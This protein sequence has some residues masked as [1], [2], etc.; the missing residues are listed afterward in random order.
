MITK[1]T[2]ISQDIKRAASVSGKI[3]F[4]L[5]QSIASSSVSCVREFGD[6]GIPVVGVL[7]EKGLEG[8]LGA[9]N[10][11]HRSSQ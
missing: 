5:P 10:A 8:L 7:P 4:A 9:L 11:I 6:D 1:K 3:G 2:S